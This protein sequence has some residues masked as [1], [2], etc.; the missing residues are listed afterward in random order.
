MRL[1]TSGVDCANCIYYQEISRV[2]GRCFKRNKDYWIGHKIQCEDM[3][4][5]K[6]EYQD[7]ED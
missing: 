3:E 1:I 5:L 4:V 2:K 6:D 7:K